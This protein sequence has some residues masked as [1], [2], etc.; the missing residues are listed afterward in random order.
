[1]WTIRF[2]WYF[3]EWGAD[4]QSNAEG[5]CRNCCCRFGLSADSGWQTIKNPNTSCGYGSHNGI[6]GL[7]IS[8]E[9]LYQQRAAFSAVLCICR[10]HCAVNAKKVGKIICRLCLPQFAVQQYINSLC[11]WR[12]AGLWFGL[13]VYKSSCHTV[14]W[15]RYILLFVKCRR[16]AGNG[17]SGHKEMNNIHKIPIHDIIWLLI[18]NN[19]FGAFE[20]IFPFINGKDVFE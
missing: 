5:R 10:Q 6:H 9:K 3:L 13:C 7:S 17:D 14:I 8:K 12:M 16:T 15:G 19:L 18:E 2:F 11:G 1:M 20:N 4:Q